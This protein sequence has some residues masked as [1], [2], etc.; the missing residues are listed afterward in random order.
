MFAVM[1]EN[2]SPYL[3][4]N[5]QVRTQQP[6]TVDP[7]DEGF[8]ES[9]LMHAINGYVYGNM[10]GLTV[11]QG[12]RVR[13]YV[14]RIGTEV[15]LHTPH[16]HSQTLLMSGMRMDMVELLPMSMKTLDMVPDSPGTWLYHCHVNDHITAGMQALFNVTPS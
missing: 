14:V 6:E 5:V 16:W 1:D 9:N 3:D 12:E 11:K 15:D 4:E 10:P 8:V 2:A 7:E 13:W